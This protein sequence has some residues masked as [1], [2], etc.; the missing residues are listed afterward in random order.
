MATAIDS[1]APLRRQCDITRRK[2]YLRRK[3]RVCERCGSPF[4]EGKRS[5]KQLAA[6]YEQ[7]FCSRA[8]ASDSKRVHATKAAAKRAEYARAR[9]RKGLSAPFE[10]ENRECGVCGAEFVAKVKTARRCETCRTGRAGRSPRPCEDCGQQVTG[11]AA[12]RLCKACRK[13]RGREAM[14]RAH[15]A[16]KRH[17]Q[18][19]R[20]F[21]V[22]YEPI[23]PIK[24]F[25]R[26]GW[27]CQMCGAKTPKQLRGTCDTRA[28]EL[29]HRTPMAMGGDHTWGNVQCSCRACNLRKGAT[30]AEGQLPLFA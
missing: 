7:R 18:R 30:K 11:T 23:D 1:G 28:P 17:R 10:P 5:S 15:G 13:R 9:L 27:R 21:G 2:N 29:D 12:R 22:A 6:G 25:D 20:R 26:D 24:V 8:C 4:V 16:T 14:K 3:A 19:A